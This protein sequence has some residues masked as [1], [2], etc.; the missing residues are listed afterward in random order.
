MGNRPRILFLC[1]G[2]ACRSQI[3]EAWSRHLRASKIE[4]HSAGISP[5]GLDPIAI[6]IMKESGIDLTRQSAKGIA[7]VA[8][9]PFDYVIA[10]CDNAWRNCPPFPPNTRVL[11]AIFDDPPGVASNAHSEEEVL[12]HYRRVRDEIRKYVEGLPEQLPKAKSE[13]D[14][15]DMALPSGNLASPDPV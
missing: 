11:A 2:N 13:E 3:A 4:A 9:I 6:R 5:G 8:G 10:V 15:P 12:G 1:T 7:D 14:P